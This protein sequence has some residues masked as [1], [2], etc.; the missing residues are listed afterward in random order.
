MSRS[1]M[2]HSLTLT[3]ALGG[4]LTACKGGP[5]EAEFVQ[6]CVNT[7]ATKPMCECAAKEAKST[8]STTLYSA[9]VLD[10]QGKKQEVAAIAEK[11]SFDERAAFAA[12]QFAIMGKCI[13]DT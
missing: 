7:Q 12:K 11:M 3:I 13:P 8:L 4:P 10:M 2:I 6:A 9:M 1:T 5:S